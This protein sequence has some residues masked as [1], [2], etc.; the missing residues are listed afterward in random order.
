MSELPHFNILLA[1]FVYSTV[2]MII[3][4]AAWALRRRGARP[5]N[6]HRSEEG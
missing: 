6:H 4:V 2:V 1:V 5:V 3:A